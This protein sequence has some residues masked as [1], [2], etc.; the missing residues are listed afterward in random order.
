VGSPSPAKP[1]LMRLVCDTGPL[2][3]LWEAELLF[4][5]EAAG[6]VVIPPAVQAELRRAAPGW[7]DAGWLSLRPLSPSQ[8][9]EA[10]Q[11]QGSGLLDPGEAEA[12]ALA[13]DF[14]PDWLLTDDSAARLVAQS[15][16]LEVHGS[17][18]VVLWAAAGR[19]LDLSAAESALARLAGS[20]LWISSRVL[21][22]AR[23]ALRQLCSPDSL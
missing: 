14:K 10:S 13:K 4:L 7:S 12:I 15:Q 19:Q 20:S 9:E 6:S 1:E 18:G 22:E 2:L 8:L 3:H 11:W 21:S 17:L 16:G 5:L 23:L